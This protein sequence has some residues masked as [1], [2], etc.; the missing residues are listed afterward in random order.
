MARQEEVRKKHYFQGQSGN[1]GRRKAE[2]PGNSEQAGC[3]G[4]EAT[5]RRLVE[6]CRLI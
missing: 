3:A 2:K 1:L 6:K 5:A 4:G